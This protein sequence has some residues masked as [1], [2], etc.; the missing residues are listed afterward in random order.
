MAPQAADKVSPLHHAIPEVEPV[1][2]SALM[3]QRLMEPVAVLIRHRDLTWE[4]AKREL[5]DR[6]VGSFAGV[7]WAIGHPLFLIGLYVFVFALVL[8]PHLSGV[9]DLPNGYA[10]YILSGLLPWMAV[11]ETLIKSCSAIIQNRSLVKQVVFPIEVLPVKGAV[12]SLLSQ[13]IGFAILF[14]YMLAG[15]GKVS[16]AVL[17]L[18]IC[19]LI[20][21]VMM[22]GL[23]LAL[24][25]ISVYIRDIKEMVQVFGM[26]GAYITPIFY[27]PDWVPSMFQPLLYVNPF[28]YMVWSYQ[29][30]LYYNGVAHL[31]AWGGYLLFA[32]TSLYGGHRVFRQLKGSF[33]SAL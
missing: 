12:V 16:V 19:L 3:L 24:S 26:A 32:L 15:R 21:L 8:R 33:A 31:W 14:L 9:S 10:V 6:H 22:I 28:S 13:L 27:L 4:L 25:A 2:Q 17:L 18:P 20:Q 23:A 7:L 30:V 5:T 1:R 11:Q 29:D